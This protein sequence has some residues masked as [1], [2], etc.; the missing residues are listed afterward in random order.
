MPALLRPVFSVSATTSYWLYTKE[1]FSCLIRYTAL[2]SDRTRRATCTQQ[3]EIFDCLNET[4]KP[5]TNNG[6]VAC[7]HRSGQWSMW[8][9]IYSVRCQEIWKPVCR[10]DDKPVF[11]TIEGHTHCSNNGH[12]SRNDSRRRLD[13]KLRYPVNDTYGKLFP[14]HTECFSGHLRQAADDVADDYGVPRT[15]AW[16]YGA[17]R[18]NNRF[19]TRRYVTQHQH[20]I[21]SYVTVLTYA[22]NNYVYWSTN[23]KPFKLV[24]SWYPPGLASLTSTTIPLDA[25]NIDSSPAM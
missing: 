16:A 15:N 21:G 4:A 14:I 9:W 24:L 1:S 20:D 13:I 22:Y 17:I 11:K 5:T 18:R 7:F 3:S 8:P 19:P 25:N 23:L 6:S 2:S 12:R 10:R